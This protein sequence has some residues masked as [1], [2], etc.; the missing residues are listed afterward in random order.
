MK[1]DLV[2]FDCY[3]TLIDWRRG[4]RQAFL[5]HLPMS[6]TVEADDLFTAF[7]EV[8]N[9]IEAKAYRPYHQVLHEAVTGVAQRFGWN[10]APF[11]TGF[12]TASLPSW[13]PFPDVNPA[14][15]HL[16]ELGYRI[17]ILSN[18]D[19]DLLAGTLRHFQ[20]PTDLLITAEQVQSY[21]PSPRH[22]ERAV[23]AVAGDPRR[24]LHMAQ[25]H[26]HDVQAAVPLGL[27]VIWVNRH[28]AALPGG[29]L[30]PL[31]EVRSVRGAVEWLDSSGLRNRRPL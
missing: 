7:T 13:E 15:K 26:Y 10:L 16:S 30:K 8:Q 29:G 4:I 6:S 14:L 31:A 9:E 25:S 27:S 19:D 5:E 20:V 28:G 12:L 1:P 2:T 17:G 3:G 23:E 18:V 22:F 24:I 11:D 21:K